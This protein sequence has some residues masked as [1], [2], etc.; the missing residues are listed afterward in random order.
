LN[1]LKFTPPE[2]PKEKKPIGRLPRPVKIRGVH[3]K[4]ITE[5]RKKTGFSTM[6]IYYLI[7]EK[8]RNTKADK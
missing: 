2:Q 7:G 5:A 8:Y 3:Y 1:P 4:S 6:R